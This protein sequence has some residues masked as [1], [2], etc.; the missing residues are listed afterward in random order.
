MIQEAFDLAEAG[1]TPYSPPPAHLLHPSA[2]AQGMAH[3]KQHALGMLI[4][5]QGG[6]HVLFRSMAEWDLLSID[7]SEDAIAEF[8][9]TS[10][11]LLQYYEKRA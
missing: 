1:S 3:A 10:P 9:K 6:H 7:G 4:G 5:P 11:L 8:L 2:N